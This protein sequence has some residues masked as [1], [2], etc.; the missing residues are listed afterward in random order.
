MQTALGT[1]F[2]ATIAVGS[3]IRLFWMGKAKA[4]HKTTQL[5][6]EPLLVDEDEK[7]KGVVSFHSYANVWVGVCARVCLLS[8]CVPNVLQ[9]KHQT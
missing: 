5:L 7:I 1:F 9:L 3:A 6:V 4:C 2:G 8:L